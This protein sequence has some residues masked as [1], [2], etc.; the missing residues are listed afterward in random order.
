MQRIVFS[1][2]A[3]HDES[4]LSEIWRRVAKYRR[5]WHRLVK[6]SLDNINNL[7]KELSQQIKAIRCLRADW[8]SL[9]SEVVR[10]AERL[11]QLRLCRVQ[12]AQDHNDHFM[13]GTSG[14]VKTFNPCLIGSFYA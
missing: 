13:F 6:A 2:D 3:E 1:A 10:A 12:A 5:Y 14:G 4:K 11:E 7:D 9:K 8:K